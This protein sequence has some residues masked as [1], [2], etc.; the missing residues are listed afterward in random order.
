MWYRMRT[1]TFSAAQ[2]SYEERL[3]SSEVRRERLRQDRMKAS[4][5]VMARENVNGEQFAQCLHNLVNDG[6][7]ISK[8][9]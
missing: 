3:N 4:E 8:R 2:L 5:M 7:Q 6:Y 9:K 1:G